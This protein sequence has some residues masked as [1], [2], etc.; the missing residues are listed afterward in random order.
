MTHRP[1]SYSHIYIHTYTNKGRLLHTYTQVQN[2]NTQLG[3]CSNVKNCLQFKYL[4]VIPFCMQLTYHQQSQV[5]C[6]AQ[7]KEVSITLPLNFALKWN[8]K[9][10]V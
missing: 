7:R 8:R 4:C 3:F 5:A 1:K 10:D 6:Q 2:K 9:N